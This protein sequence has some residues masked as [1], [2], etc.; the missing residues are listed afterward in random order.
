MLPENAA[1]CFFK[2]L[3]LVFDKNK[4]KIS[5]QQTLTLDGGALSPSVMVE[6]CLKFVKS[7]CKF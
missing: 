3:C 2:G 4:T 5:R 1:L 7:H 6:S